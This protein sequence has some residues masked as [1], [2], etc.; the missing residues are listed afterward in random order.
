MQLKRT[1]LWL[2]LI[3]VIGTVFGWKLWQKQS[4]TNS[5]SVAQVKGPAVILFRGDNDPGCQTIYRLVDEAAS[6]HDRQIQFV[7]LDWSD[8]N[9]LIQKYQIRFLPS[10]VFV[11]KQDKEIERVVGESPA[12]QQKLKQALMRVDEILLH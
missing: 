4:A 8:D 11:D 3:I 2:L 9:P 1:G 7:R 5:P 6:Q 10:V 12:V